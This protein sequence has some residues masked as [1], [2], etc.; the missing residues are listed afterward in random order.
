MSS[1]SPIKVGFVGLSSKGWASQS[2]GPGLTQP[3]L[4]DKY[5]LVAVSTTSPASALESAKKWSVAAGRG[6]KA[7]HG[8]VTNLIEGEKDNVDLVA[9]SVKAP[10]HRDVV[11]KVIEA[12]KDFFVEWP[13]GKS[14]AETREIRDAASK[15]GVRA[16]VG[17]QG[18]HSPVINKVKEIISSGKIGKVLSSNII[19]NIALD[20]QVWFN[21]VSN[22]RYLLDKANGATHLTIHIG[23]H[24]DN[25]TYL[26]GNLTSISATGVTHYPKTTVLDGYNG[27]PTG[28]VLPGIGNDHL[29][30]TGTLSTGILVTSVWKSVNSTTP[31]RNNFLWEIDGTEGTI[32]LTKEGT[33]M[34]SFTSLCEP[35]LYVNGEKVEVEGSEKGV[36]GFVERNWEEFAKGEEGRHATLDDA[37]RLKS[38]LEAI[39]E[40]LESGKRVSF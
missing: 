10:S 15:A 7:Y 8:D 23:H 25:L 22:A 6:V 11:L 27:K 37:V 40:S 17:L 33:P 21:E 38:Y 20:N 19:G 31:G 13:V 24:L 34:A 1:T 30:I 2:L 28:E 3:S 26:L 9:I 35:D 36:V 29:A 16:L 18:R 39:D 32:R 12:K 4:R 14:P 5:A